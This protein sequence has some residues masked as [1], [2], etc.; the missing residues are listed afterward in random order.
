MLF[1]DSLRFKGYWLS[2]LSWLMLSFAVP[3]TNALAETD[4]GTMRICS[5]HGSFWL[6]A[7]GD[8]HT[9]NSDIPFD[10]CPCLSQLLSLALPGFFTNS[11]EPITPTLNNFQAPFI[12]AA[13]Y[14]WLSRAPP[15]NSF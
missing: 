5:T 11:F 2:L 13:N 10:D 7:V 6:E 1:R 8:E 12:A 3:V 15:I 9:A 4:A 14:S